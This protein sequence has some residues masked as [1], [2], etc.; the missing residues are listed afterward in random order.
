MGSEIS[1]N[2]S[3]KNGIN[4]GEENDKENTSTKSPKPKFRRPSRRSKRKRIPPPK[5]FHR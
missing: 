2:E 1:G 4:G 5:T 3:L